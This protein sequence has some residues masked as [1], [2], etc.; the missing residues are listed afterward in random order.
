MCAHVLRQIAQDQAGQG[1]PESLKLSELK[2]T[3][4]GVSRYL[5]NPHTEA[6]R[7]M[8]KGMGT[9]GTTRHPK[10]TFLTRMQGR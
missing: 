6:D 2:I 10:R 7:P 4:F 5:D 8:T 1:G 3:D 9:T